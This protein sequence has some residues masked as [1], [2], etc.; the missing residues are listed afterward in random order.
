MEIRKEEPKK[1]K[2]PQNPEMPQDENPMSRPEKT[3]KDIKND[4]E[5]PKR[6][7]EEDNGLI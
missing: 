3:R 1:V 5:N 6:Q 7:K 2:T 4:K